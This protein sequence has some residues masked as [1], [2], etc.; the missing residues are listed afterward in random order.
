MRNIFTEHLFETMYT[1]SVAQTV[2]VRSTTLIPIIRN[3]H[4][5]D[6]AVEIDLDIVPRIMPVSPVAQK[7]KV[8]LMVCRVD[9][10]AVPGAIRCQ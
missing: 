3:P 9:F 5:A 1:K 2:K 4:L 10:S 7:E 8:I 6:K